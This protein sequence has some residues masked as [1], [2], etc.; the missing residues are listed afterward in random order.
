VLYSIVLG[1]S[2][3]KSG[4]LFGEMLF[5]ALYRAIVVIIDLSANLRRK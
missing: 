5:S 2:R 4:A 3:I 1:I